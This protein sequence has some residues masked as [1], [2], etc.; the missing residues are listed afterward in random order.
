M[1]YGTPA[2]ASQLFMAG[3]MLA[4]SACG[5]GGSSS[6]PPTPPPPPPASALFNDVTQSNL[7]VSVISQSC[8]DAIPFDYDRDNDQDVLLA[9]EF[10]RMVL[11]QNDGNGRFSDISAEAGML[12]NT[13]DHEDADVGDFDQDGD[14]DI[15]VASEDTMVHEAYINQGNSFNGSQ[16]SPTS[17]ANAVV[18]FDFDQDGD[19][20]LVFGGQN[21][22]ILTNNGE[23]TFSLYTGDRIP[24][25]ANT[26][27]DIAIN[28]IDGDGD[29]DVMLGIEGQNRLLLNDGTGRYSDVTAAYLPMVEDESRVIAFADIDNDGDADMFV[30]NVN[31]QINPLVQNNFIYLNDGAGRFAGGQSTGLGFGTYGGRFVDFDGDGDPDL[32]TANANLL[33]PDNMDG[34]KLYRNT[35]GSFVEITS[36]A[37]GSPVAAHGFSVATADFNRDGKM[38]LYFCS[39]GAVQSGVKVGNQDRLMFQR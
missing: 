38:D 34:F 16:L 6:P 32:I 33:V 30:G 31:Q 13:Q 27:Q 14:L 5:G 23:G 12:N 39:R 20:D 7:P 19:L 29:M 24:S 11:L 10:G 28:D 25:I 18:A 36:E 3:A 8:M 9:I 1:K 4:L 26:I 21:L 37:F 35:A 22:L 15:V 2:S 17:V